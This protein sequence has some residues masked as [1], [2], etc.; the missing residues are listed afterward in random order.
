[1]RIFLLLLFALLLAQPCSAVTSET[2]RLSNPPAVRMTCLPSAESVELEPVFL[3]PIPANTKQQKTYLAEASRQNITIGMQKVGPFEEDEGTFQTTCKT[4]LHTVSGLFS[5][6]NYPSTQSSDGVAILA[7]GQCDAFTRLELTNLSVD[8]KTWGQWPNFLHYCGGETPM[9]LK[10][11]VYPAQ[12]RMTVC[13]IP[14]GGG[15]GYIFKE[16]FEGTKPPPQTITC[17]DIEPTK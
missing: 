6:V 11:T 12:N 17:Q 10:L 1:M 7:K 14:S 8:G 9:V 15:P 4:G 16:A 2:M 3:G 5:Y 13:T